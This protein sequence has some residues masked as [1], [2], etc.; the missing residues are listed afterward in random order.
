MGPHDD[1][2][3]LPLRAVS[4]VPG[5][6]RRV[7]NLRWAKQRAQQARVHRPGERAAAGSGCPRRAHAR[8]LPWKPTPCIGPLWQ[9]PGLP[10]FNLRGR[11]YNSEHNR[12]RGGGSHCS[13]AGFRAFD[14]CVAQRRDPRRPPRHT[15]SRRLA[16]LP[17]PHLAISRSADMGCSR[18]PGD[19]SLGRDCLVRRNPPIPAPRRRRPG[20]SYKVRTRRANG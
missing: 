18:T 20:R 15:G 4:T 8:N 6:L 12:S 7:S 3:P 14:V 16:A 9:R 17:Q 13:V 10:P 19:Y 2:L 11:I 1:F 5:R